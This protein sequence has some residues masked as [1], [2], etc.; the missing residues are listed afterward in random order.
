[1][2]VACACLLLLTGLQAA[3]AA[4]AQAWKGQIVYFLLT[5]RFAQAP[6]STPGGPCKLTG[7]NNGEA[8][9]A[10]TCMLADAR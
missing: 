4:D 6:G 10:A 3:L 7:W 1:M 8:R 5:D 9:H 2:W